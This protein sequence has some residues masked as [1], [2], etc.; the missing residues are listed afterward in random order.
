MREIAPTAVN[1]ASESVER[2]RHDVVLLRDRVVEEILVM[3]S[4]GS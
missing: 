2:R 4:D 3:L 1:H